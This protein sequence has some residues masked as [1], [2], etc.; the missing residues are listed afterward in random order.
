M[1]DN[2]VMNDSDASFIDATGLD[3]MFNE[4]AESANPKKVTRPASTQEP[5]KG[6]PE[7]IVVV[8]EENPLDNENL[9][10][11]ELAFIHGKSKTAKPPKD[12]KTEAAGAATENDDDSDDD[13][14][15]PENKGKKGEDNEE[16]DELEHSDD[17]IA[18]VQATAEMMFESGK[19]EKYDG[20]EDDVKNMTP[21]LYE[22][23]SEEQFNYKLQERF[24]KSFE[25]L[26][27]AAQKIIQYEMDGG[28]PENIIALFKEQKQ[29]SSLDLKKESDRRYVIETYHREVAKYD[30][31]EIEDLIESMK[32]NKTE[33]AQAE[34]FLKK[35][36]T[37][38]E[39]KIDNTVKEQ[40]ETVAKNKEA[41]EK[42]ISS[43]NEIVSKTYNKEES[44]LITKAISEKVKLDNGKETT[45][46][47][48][49]FLEIQKDPL[50]F[51]Q[52][53]R[54]IMNQEKLEKTEKTK[55]NNEA[56]ESKFNQ[57]FKNRR[58]T[59]VRDEL[60]KKTTQPGDLTFGV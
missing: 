53:V 44:A 26:G 54:Y 23:I 52:L 8:K 58:R 38:T 27:P 46:Y 31:D 17:I 20:W 24:N 29:L 41:R 33:E 14:E 7:N 6:T 5:G 40:S 34:K 30:D 37:L 12:K 50:K 11:D 48:A 25:R 32:L 18:G 35:L 56:V 45:P 55:K 47:L 2:V 1:F 9:S 19:W 16:D 43:V 60:D 15:E 39:Y 3:A 4:G 51:T 36:Q 28:D 13:D 21:E 57:F 49:K 22:E 59:E 42:F 10:E